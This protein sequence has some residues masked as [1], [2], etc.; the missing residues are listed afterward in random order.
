VRACVRACVCVRVRVRV[1]VR[2]K[3]WGAYSDVKITCYLL[4]QVTTAVVED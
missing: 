3:G 2:V 1:C 4:L